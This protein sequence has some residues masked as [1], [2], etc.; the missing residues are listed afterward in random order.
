MHHKLM[1]TEQQYSNIGRELLGVVFAL[2]RLNHYTYG[3][4][5]TVQSDHKPLMSIWKKTIAAASSRLQRL[6]LRLSKYDI[7]ID[8]LQGKENV[9][10][11][12]LSRVC[13]LPPTQQD[14]ELETIL[15]HITS[16][17]VPATAT[18]F[19]SF[20]TPLKMTIL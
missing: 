4:T 8:Y 2:R 15:I 14:Y 20:E 13:P 18:N 11:D 12:A 1:E 7:K 19:K 17:T 10:A 16:N 3:F 9:I 5:I 6:L